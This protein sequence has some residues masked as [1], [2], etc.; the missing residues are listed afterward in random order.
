MRLIYPSLYHCYKTGEQ[1][2]EAIQAYAAIVNDD[3]DHIKDNAI[4][5]TD[6][7]FTYMRRLAYIIQ[8][9]DK[10]EDHYY[11]MGKNFAGIIYVI[12]IEE[13]EPVN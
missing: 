8:V 4:Y 10:T 3:T 7:Y 12:L 2:G 9:S 5:K 1:T 11:Y 13:D 6:P